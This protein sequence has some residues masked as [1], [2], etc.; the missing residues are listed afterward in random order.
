MRDRKKSAVGGEKQSR[1]PTHDVYNQWLHLQPYSP[2]ACVKYAR[3]S[4]PDTITN[5]VT[6]TR[7]HVKRRPLTCLRCCKDCP[8]QEQRQPGDGLRT[9]LM[10]AFRRFLDFPRQPHMLATVHFAVGRNREQI[11]TFPVARSR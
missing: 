9:M 4:A 6:V 2:R 5:A 7:W 8:W 3:S 1:V 11:G 10:A